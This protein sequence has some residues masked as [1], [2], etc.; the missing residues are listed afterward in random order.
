MSFDLEISNPFTTG[1]DGQV[2]N[3]FTP[4]LALW[5][6]LRRSILH[7][8]PSRFSWRCRRLCAHLGSS[9]AVGPIVTRGQ[10]IGEIIQFDGIPAHLRHAL[11]GRRNNV[12]PG[13]NLYD[14]FVSMAG[15]AIVL[16][17]RFFQDGSAPQVIDYGS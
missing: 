8:P 13:M 12:Y 1:F 6:H 4:R 3:I 5:R 10:V 9:V 14:Y 17:V 16:H 7:P 2:T 11:G 15:T